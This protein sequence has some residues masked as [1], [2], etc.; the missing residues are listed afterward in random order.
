MKENKMNEMDGIDTILSM[1]CLKAINECHPV[2]MLSSLMASALTM[3][4]V[5]IDACDD[6]QK[7]E[8][9]EQLVKATLNGLVEASKDKKCL[10]YKR[11]VKCYKTKDNG[12]KIDN[13]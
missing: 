2:E 13:D 10:P 6:E 4:K 12:Q 11:Y 9:G 3:Q 1:L 7:A 5:M 8:M